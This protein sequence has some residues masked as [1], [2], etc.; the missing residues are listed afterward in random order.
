MASNP[1]DAYHLALTEEQLKQ[2][3][4]WAE[5]ANVLDRKAEFLNALKTIYQQLTME[6]VTWGDPSY[7][8]TQLGLQLYHRV[9]RP[10]TSL[11]R[12]MK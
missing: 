10:C 11:M 5:R 1:A 9:S 2:L 6:P 8:L 3:R 4:T 12:S 7:R